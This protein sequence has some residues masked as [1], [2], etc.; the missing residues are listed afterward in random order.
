[1]NLVVEGEGGKCLSYKP[2]ASSPSKK[3]YVYTPLF[4]PWYPQFCVGM[5]N[6]SIL[7]YFIATY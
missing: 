7:D 2:Q 6:I 5:R 4:Y 3:K 1:M